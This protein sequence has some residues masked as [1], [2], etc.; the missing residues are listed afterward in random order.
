MAENNQNDEDSDDDIQL[1]GR[2]VAPVLTFLVF[3]T[4]F[5]MRKSSI[6]GVSSELSSLVQIQ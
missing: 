3:I 1:Q 5:R 4:V 6:L 2:D